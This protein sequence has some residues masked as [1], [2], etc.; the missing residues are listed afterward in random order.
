MLLSL[1]G[2]WFQSR[3]EQ[4]IQAG[5]SR[6]VWRLPGTL[7]CLPEH[8]ARHRQLYVYIHIYILYII[9]IIIIIVLEGLILK[10]AA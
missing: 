4:G 6:Q 7:Q 3:R 5:Y 1:G 9:I 2:I 10:I 8:K